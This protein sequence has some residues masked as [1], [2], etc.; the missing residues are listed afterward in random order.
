MK[1][2]LVAF[3]AV[4]LALPS[5]LGHTVTAE[6]WGAGIAYETWLLFNTIV[7]IGI[8]FT[9]RNIFS[10]WGGVLLTGIYM[11]LFSVYT[12]ITPITVSLANVGLGV[13]AGVLVYVAAT[14]AQFCLLKTGSR[15]SYSVCSAMLTASLVSILL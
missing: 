14:T 10:V 12:G 5:Y 11:G 13:L 8:Y 6:G 4:V 3:L 1:I 2:F 7:V 9:T 15:E